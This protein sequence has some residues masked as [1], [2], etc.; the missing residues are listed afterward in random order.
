MSAYCTPAKASRA[1]VGN[2]MFVKVQYILKPY[3]TA[4]VN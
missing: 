2:K 3:F 4:K 1:A